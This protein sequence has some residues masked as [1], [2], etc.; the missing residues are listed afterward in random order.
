MG[1][2]DHPVLIYLLTR[3]WPCC[4]MQITY[5]RYANLRAPITDYDDDILVAKGRE[6]IQ[7]QDGSSVYEFVKEKTEPDVGS[8]RIDYFE[9]TPV[10]SVERGDVLARRVLGVPGEN[11][12]NVYGK[13]ITVPQPKEKPIMFGDG[14]YLSEDELTAYAEHDGLPLL[15]NGA[16]ST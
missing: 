4:T 10:L 3:L 13:E 9:L 6:P 16:Q 12:V 1:E 2:R 8:D 14:V 5:G 7:P 11:G 15:Q